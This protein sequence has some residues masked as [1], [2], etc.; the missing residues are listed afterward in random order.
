VLQIALGDRDEA[1]RPSPVLCYGTL[2]EDDDPDWVGGLLDELRS[3][4]EGLGR[5]VDASDIQRLEEGCD[6][7]L[8]R[9]WLRLPT[10][11]RPSV[12]L[13]RIKLPTK[14]GAA[15]KT[16]LPPDP[17]RRQVIVAMTKADRARCQANREGRVFI[18]RREVAVVEL[19]LSARALERD[20]LLDRLD[21][22]HRLDPGTML[23]Q[24]PFRPDVYVEAEKAPETIARAK[25][26]H[27]SQMCQI[28]GAQTVA[29]EEI[30]REDSSS[31]QTWSAGGKATGRGRFEG[32]TQGGKLD[33][34]VREVQ[35]FHRF[36]G[37]APD[38]AAAEQYLREHGLSGDAQLEALVEM[39]GRDNRLLEHRLHVSTQAELQRVR[40]VVSNLKL[41][42]HRLQAQIEAAST[43]AAS[44]SFR[45][46]VVI[47]PQAASVPE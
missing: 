30:T 7:L 24:N 8:S 35:M 39:C 19:P 47:A 5:R 1:G 32:S 45:I 10:L 43:E 42:L 33:T 34:L 2:P 14:K 25:L 46:A 21:S 22:S 26:F 41:P 38:I 23:V 20:D 29:I 17:A 40:E 12:P 13:P 9:S 36:E 18:G 16:V 44:Y 3:F 4:V 11:P 37:D 28:L 6:A 31:T 27:V 15:V